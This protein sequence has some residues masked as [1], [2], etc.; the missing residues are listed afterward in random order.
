MPVTA[1]KKKGDIKITVVKKM[2]D[3]SSDPTFRKKAEKV[4]AFLQKHGLPPQ[5]KKK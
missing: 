4:K 2:R 3:Y 1:T 5:A